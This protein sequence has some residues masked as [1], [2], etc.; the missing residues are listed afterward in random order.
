MRNG[1]DYYTLE[2]GDQVSAE[3][4]D[5]VFFLLGVLVLCWC[6]SVWCRHGAGGDLFLLCA[7]RGKHWELWF[8]PSDSVSKWHTGEEPAGWPPGFS[9][10]HMNETFGRGDSNSLRLCS[11]CPSEEGVA[12]L[13]S[14][15][16][17]VGRHKWFCWEIYSKGAIMWI[18]AWSIGSF[19]SIRKAGLQF[20]KVLT[21]SHPSLELS[22]SPPLPRINI[23]HV[24]VTLTFILRNYIIYCCSK[25]KKAIP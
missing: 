16:S 10:F 5:R 4:G 13:L 1:K 19:P 3:R 7:L 25:N 11:Q 2:R 24:W 20:L 8:S 15:W 21:S 22:I 9:F 14:S 17:H 23:D 18:E 6:G 12:H